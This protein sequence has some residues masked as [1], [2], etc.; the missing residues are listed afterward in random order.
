[1]RIKIQKSSWPSGVFER[2]KDMGRNNVTLN[3][4]TGRLQE[5]RMER[6]RRLWH[7]G[8]SIGSA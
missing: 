6:V 4:G 1:M 7:D 8:I 3:I 5:K 2:G